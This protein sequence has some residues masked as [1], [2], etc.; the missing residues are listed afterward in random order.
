MYKIFY[1][2]TLIF[3]D[4]TPLDEVK[5]IDPILTR[6]A[7]AAGSLE[8]TIPPCN[9]SY[10]L[11]QRMRGIIK[12]TKND[13]EIWEGRVLSEN[14]DFWKNKRIYC[15]GELAF[16]I[17]TIQPQNIY[18]GV[19]MIQ[20]VEGLLS[21][22]NQKVDE[23]K[24]FELGI[25]TV[26][27]GIDIG[28]RVTNFETTFDIFK[29]LIGEFG[30][31]L[32]V[33]HADGK[34]YL[35][36]REEPPRSSM[37]KI[38]FGTNL[39]DFTK[40][41]D[42]SSLCTVLL[43]LG[44]TIANSGQSVVGEQMDAHL[45][46]QHYIDPTDYNSYYDP[47]LSADYVASNSYI[48]VEA[49]KTYYISCRNREGR[50][51]WALKDS[52]G[53]LVDYYAASS[54]PG[55]TDLVEH[56][57]TIPKSDAGN[58][59]YLIVAGFGS[60]IM[61]RVNSA[62]TAD[63]NFDEYT[64]V[65]SVNNGSLYVVNQEAVTNYGWIEKQLSWDDIEDSQS[66]KEVAEKYLTEG[67]FDEMSL[68]VTA[69]DLQSMGFDE[70]SIDILDEVQ[71]VSTPHGLNKVFPVTK[72]TIHLANPSSDTFILGYETEQT[73]TGVSSSYNNDILNKIK[74]L[75]SQSATLKS[76][77]KNASE[78]IRNAT[79]GIFQLEFDERGNTIGARLSN[80]ADW[81]A[82][83]AKGWRFN[84]GGIGYF[85]NGWDNDVTIAI[86]GEDG[87]LVANSITTGTMLANHIRGGTLG[88]GHWLMEDGSYLD[89]ELIVYDSAGTDIVK[90][91]QNGAY[92]KGEFISVGDENRTVW[93]KDG[94]IRGAQGVAG[95]ALTLD[96]YWDDGNVGCS[97]EADVVYLQ[98]KKRIV[99]E[100]PTL[101]TNDGAY[102]KTREV[103]INSGNY[104]H[105]FVFNN[106][107]FVDYS[108]EYD[109]GE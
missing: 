40:K 51:M 57:L 78:L 105:K 24:K 84:M 22:H 8:F 52:A 38:E 65:E 63:E 72:Q 95:P 101:I 87:G 13:K 42:M 73:L 79:S 12:V 71:V 2:D 7:N 108:S 58:D 21:I 46:S 41:Y 44:K 11:I 36:Y 70:D 61:T 100:T 5:L 48:P 77:K 91:N 34:R 30:G 6:E 53:N 88:L 89:G 82:E 49:E 81:E 55:F 19:T 59:Y 27:S 80:V 67:Q 32:I 96:A 99:L 68:E 64:T 29:N 39:M 94:W 28:T 109:G 102:G 33:R 60:D 31:Y 16:L 92:V 90:M 25:V 83:G 43:P 107:L 26:A 4:K 97:I 85:G 18:S 62:I 20:L 86:T 104:I 50:I 98:G 37:Q 45:A 14:E 76:A 15:E 56:K 106:G 1:N 93:I 17:D 3:Y 66:L 75:P 9:L 54:S 10:N 47:N 35:D 74:A 23:T 103:T 69:V